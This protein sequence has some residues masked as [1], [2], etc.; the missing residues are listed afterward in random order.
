M[1]NALI[2]IPGTNKSFGGDDVFVV[3]EIGKGFIQTKEDQS[4]ETYLKNAIEL[5]DAAVESGADAVK[6]QTHVLEDEVLNIDFTS[7]H[8]T[9]SDRYNWV[10][11]NEEATPIKEFWAPLV[12]HCKKKGIIFFSTAMSKKAARKLEENFNVPFWKVGSGDVTDHVLLDYICETGKPII[13]STGMVS[14]AELDEV[15]KYITEKGSPLVVLYCVSEYPCPLDHFNLGTIEHFIEK[16]P[17]VV[18]GFSDHSVDSNDVDL[19][20]VKLGARMI[21]KHFTFDRKLWGSDH[22]ASVLPHEMKQLVN[23]IREENYEK[24]DVTPYYGESGRELNGAK[25]QFRPYFHKALMIGSDISKG[26]K[27]TKNVIF[28]MRPM[29]YAGGMHANKFG[30]VLGKRVTKDIKKFDP[31]TESILE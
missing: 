12:E 7:P 22:K 17:N 27:L 28:A 8:F 9:G 26:T 14:L 15:I 1:R 20:A 23:D 10:K 18:I 11:R 29:M 13:I 30:E 4:V 24:I 5:V 6:F 19:A 16:Y 21:E 3:A 31:I 2:P 25:N